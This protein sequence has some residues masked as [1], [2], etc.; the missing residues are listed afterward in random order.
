MVDPEIEALIRAEAEAL[1]IKQRHIPADEIVER[2]LLRLANEGAKILE[3]GCAPR[4]R[5]RRHVPQR[6]RLPG[7]ARRADV[8]GR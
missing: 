8:A 6:L 2:C 1:Q 5:L 4:Q 7:L 3:E